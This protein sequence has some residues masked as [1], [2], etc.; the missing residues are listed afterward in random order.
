M[1]AAFSCGIL[2]SV[3][4]QKAWGLFHTQVFYILK[5]QNAQH[6][7]SHGFICTCSHLSWKPVARKSISYQLL[8]LY[9]HFCPQQISLGMSEKQFERAQ[10]KRKLW[11]QPNYAFLFPGNQISIG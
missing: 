4:I 10:K 7:K 6:T 1:H 3:D 9:K 11:N 8:L 5:L 2:P